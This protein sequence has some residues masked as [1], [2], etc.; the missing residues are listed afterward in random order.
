MGFPKGSILGPL[1]FNIFI[2]DIFLFID[3]SKIVNYADD[4]TLYTVDRD[5]IGVIDTLEREILTL[6]NWFRDNEMKP[7]EAKSN[8]LVSKVDN[9]SINVGNEMVHASTFVKLLGITIDYKLNFTEHIN[10]ICRKASQKFHA[11]ARVA[12]YINSDKLRIIMKAFFDSQFNY[13]PL[14]WM[15]H[16]RTLNNKINRLHERTLR[17]VYKNQILI[18]Q[19]LL[20]VDGPSTIHHRNLQKLATEKYKVRNKLSPIPIQH[21][22]TEINTSYNLRNQRVWETSNIHTSNYGTAS[23]TYLGPKTWD[24]L[25]VSIKSSESLTEFKM[26]VKNWKPVG[27]ICRLCKSYIANVGFM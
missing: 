10:N 4:N 21:L 11:L 1:L 13:C 5:A 27:C 12:K 14:V 26:K 17:L 8:L 18:F 23:I 24:I 3:E 6:L 20:D 19:E 25:P 2:N 15:F 7:N 16:S 9:L 22:F